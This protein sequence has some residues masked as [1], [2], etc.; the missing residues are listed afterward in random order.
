MHIA[1]EDDKQPRTCSDGMVQ[2]LPSWHEL[3]LSAGTIC[4]SGGTK[5]EF[6]RKTEQDQGRKERT[7]GDLVPERLLE[8]EGKEAKAINHHR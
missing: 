8:V 2:G 6:F 3:V 5:H 7:R 1:K 4:S